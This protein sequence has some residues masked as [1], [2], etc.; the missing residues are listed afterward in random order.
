M[1]P[2]LPVVILM[3]LKWRLLLFI[4]SVLASKR[5]TADEAYQFQPD[6]SVGYTDFLF[7]N[8]R[9]GCFITNSHR[10]GFL[11]FDKFSCQ[12]I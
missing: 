5:N 10:L 11:V 9:S 3:T 6:F 12:I 7:I 8:C 1:A 2:S 4:C